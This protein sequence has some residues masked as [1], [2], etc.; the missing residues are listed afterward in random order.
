MK[1]I[2]TIAIAAAIIFF[3][4]MIA[5]N[6][7]DIKG[8]P[9]IGDTSDSLNLYDL[10]F[11]SFK[12]GNVSLSQYK[13]TPLIVNSWAVWCPFC[14]NELKDFAI[15]QEEL[16]DSALVIVINRGESLSKQIDFLNSVELIDKLLYLQDPEDSFYKVI[17]GFAM[18]ETLF[19]GADGAIVGH[20]RGVIDINEMR[21]LVGKI[22]N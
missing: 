21:D 20:K 9:R 19:V 11:T 17:G 10:S 16:G 1:R 22:L 3:L 8:T 14:K 2:I 13:G 6:P 15:L 7:G 18:P 4:V 12:G 5:K